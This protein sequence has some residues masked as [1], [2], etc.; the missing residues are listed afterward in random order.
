MSKKSVDA[1]AESL[2]IELEVAK[3]QAAD[4]LNLAKYHAAELENFRKRNM[5]S[6]HKAFND[7]RE[8][9]LL[10]ILPIMDALYEA[11]KTVETEHDRAGI[12]IL[13]R[14][15]TQTL[16]TNGVE[17]IGK[18][19][20]EFN[21]HMHEAVAVAAA[22]KCGIVLEVWQSGYIMNGKVIRP[23]TVKVSQ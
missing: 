16:T 9:V 19:G 3:K 5:E 2:M 1:N 18:V 14:K 15:F 13:I 21:P 22:E 12:E 8:R 20:E 23:A 4:N 6:A 11:M 7:G 17:E 10:Q